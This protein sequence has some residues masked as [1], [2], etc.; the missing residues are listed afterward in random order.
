M[1]S[2]RLIRDN[3]VGGIINSSDTIPFI[4]LEIGA[5]VLTGGIGSLVATA[6]AP[7]V[8]ATSTGLTVFRAARNVASTIAKLPLGI[9]P[10][11]A[12]NLG[13]I[14]GS[15][16][17][18]SIFGVGAALQ[19]TTRQEKQIAYAN[20]LVF[21]DPEMQ[22]DYDLSSIGW[23]GG[24][25][26]AIGFLGF[27]LLPQV[28][29]STAGAFLNKLKG[30]NVAPLGESVVRMTGDKRF[31]YEGTS[32]GEALGFY[33]GK[34]SRKDVAVDLPLHEKIITEAGFSA[35]EVASIN[36]GLAAKIFG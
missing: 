22:K 4:A 13:L 6:A 16:L 28:V 35:S 7:T 32:I 9:S 10:S 2:G 3:L 11:Y 30:V 36:G 29:G 23:A 33:K 5:T 21:A 34:L 8:A 18:G 24:E 31:T 14:G 19:E 20:A 17:T 15:T 26:F 27:G 1:D 25:G 12:K